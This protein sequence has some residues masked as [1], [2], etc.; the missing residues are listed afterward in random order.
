MTMVDEDLPCRFQKE[1]SLHDVSFPLHKMGLLQKKGKEYQR[2][3]VG[4]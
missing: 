3:D 1:I 2:K 4:T